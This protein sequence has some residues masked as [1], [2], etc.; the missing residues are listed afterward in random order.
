MIDPKLFSLETLIE[1]LLNDSLQPS[2]RRQCE[3]VPNYMP[4][5]PS[6][7]TR[8]AVVVKLRETFL[9]YSKGPRQGFFWDIYG[10]DFMTPEL[11]LLA[12]LEAPVPPWLLRRGEDAQRAS[13]SFGCITFELPP[14]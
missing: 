14:R 8:P 7:D 12:L 9:R 2:W 10:D 4:P 5:Y 13:K 11:A 1:A 6:K 3:I